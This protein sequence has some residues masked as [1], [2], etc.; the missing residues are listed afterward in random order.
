MILYLGCWTVISSLQ[1]TFTVR[2][3]YVLCRGLSG[4]AVE[5]E[6]V[7][8]SMLFHVPLCLTFAGHVVRPL[9]STHLKEGPWKR[10]STFADFKEALFICVLSAAEARARHLVG[11]MGLGRSRGGVADQR[12]AALPNHGEEWEGWWMGVW[13]CELNFNERQL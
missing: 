8:F 6:I 2:W 10:P 1:S 3:L 4:W 12:L 9:H 5:G 11:P 7:P 13:G